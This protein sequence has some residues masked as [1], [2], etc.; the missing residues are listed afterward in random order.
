[1]EPPSIEANVTA[2]S[3]NSGVK[4]F[5]RNQMH[6][7]KNMLINLSVFLATVG[8]ILVACGQT[9]SEFDFHQVPR[10]H[11]I[12]LPSFAHTVD[13]LLIG[14]VWGVGRYEVAE[15]QRFHAGVCGDAANVCDQ[16]MTILEVLQQGRGI[17]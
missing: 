3:Y 14:D 1:M 5:W 8:L 6:S 11:E 13:P 17:G 15:H 10:Q 4:A 9:A 2:G 7:S 16:R 12:A